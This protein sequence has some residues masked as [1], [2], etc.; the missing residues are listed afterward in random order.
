MERGALAGFAFDPDFAPQQLGQA[1]ADG[2]TQPRAAIMPGSGGIHLLKGFEQA[3][4]PLQRDADAGVA[5]REMEQPLL[6]MT[7]EIS[8]VLVA[9]RD[10]AHAVRGG[11]DFDND[12]ALLGELHAIADQVDEYLPQPG[13]V[14]D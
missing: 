3:A 7:Q 1:F 8:I 14:A 2:Q 10:A 9:G 4:L 13:D 6:R 11:A 5:H 12:F